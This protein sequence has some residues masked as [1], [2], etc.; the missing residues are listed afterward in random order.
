[1]SYQP[2]RTLLIKPKQWATQHPPLVVM[3]SPSLPC[4]PFKLNRLDVSRTCTLLSFESY[5]LKS[6]TV[7]L[8]LGLDAYTPLFA[9]Q[10][11][12]PTKWT[13]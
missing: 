6:T 4:C 13:E 11:I 5:L 7:V 3:K 9:Q 10:G 8:E 2:G 12:R 1:M